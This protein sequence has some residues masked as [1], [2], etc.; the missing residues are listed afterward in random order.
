LAEAVLVELLLQMPLGLAETQV[1]LVQLHLQVVVVAVAQY[2]P[3]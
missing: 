3:V 2:L 1:F